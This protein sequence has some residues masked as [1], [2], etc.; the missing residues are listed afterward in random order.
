MWWVMGQGYGWQ[1][2]Q[3][4][5]CCTSPHTHK[6]YFLDRSARRE[7]N[8]LDVICPYNEAGCDWEGKF[9]EYHQHINRCEHGPK[10]DIHPFTSTVSP[11][12]SLNREPTH[13]QCDACREYVRVCELK[14]HSKKCMFLS[15]GRLCPLVPLGCPNEKYMDRSTLDEHLQRSQY[16]HLTMIAN[17]IQLLGNRV[18]NTSSTQALCSDDLEVANGSSVGPQSGEMQNTLPH[19]QQVEL[20][21]YITEQL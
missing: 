13:I 5:Y 6:Q 2:V 16:D 15:Q 14:S 21:I 9:Q 7:I 12:Q 11:T 19:H 17:C 3:F 20:R 10:Q 8:N 1:C 4:L 18:V